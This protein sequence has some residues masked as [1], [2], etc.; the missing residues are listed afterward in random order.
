[1]SRAQHTRAGARAADAFLA[2]FEAERTQ[3][4]ALDESELASEESILR[5]I[6]VPPRPEA[7]WPASLHYLR[8][9]LRK[10]RHTQGA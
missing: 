3:R 1:M 2:R 7:D 8:F 4:E 6:N 5:N 9:R 10:Y